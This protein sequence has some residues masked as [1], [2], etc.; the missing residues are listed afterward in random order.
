[1]ALSLDPRS[2]LYFASPVLR[3][4]EP[5]YE[6]SCRKIS[7]RSQPKTII[8]HR[9]V[10][11]LKTKGSGSVLKKGSRRLSTISTREERKHGREMAHDLALFEQDSRS[12]CPAVVYV[13]QKHLGISRLPSYVSSQCTTAGIEEQQQEVTMAITL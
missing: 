7:R 10:G 3:V 12:R 6:H 5:G 11:S 1:M 13:D 2:T 4:L 8:F 9:V